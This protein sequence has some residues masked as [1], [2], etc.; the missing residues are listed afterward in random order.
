MTC[1][2]K[3]DITEI[4]LLAHTFTEYKID[5]SAT[6]TED[7]TKTAK[8]DFCTATD[9]KTVTGSALGLARKFKDQVSAI[10]NDAST[11]ATYAELY[12]ALQTYSTLSDVEKASVAT[13]FST[14]QQQISAYNAKAK[15]ANTSIADATEI[16]FAHIAATGF[17]FVAALLFLL[18]RKFFI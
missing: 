10:S 3:T 15:S 9:T 18:K 14:L 5:K 16:A 2:A 1:D 12:S 6:Y 7:A 8:C 11:D 13:E 4:E 17:A